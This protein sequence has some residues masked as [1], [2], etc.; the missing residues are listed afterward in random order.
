MNAVL[1]WGVG[2]VRGG[3]GNSGGWADEV[4]HVEENAGETTA[5]MTGQRGRGRWRPRDVSGE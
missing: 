4:G 1:R 2:R 3:D 5:G